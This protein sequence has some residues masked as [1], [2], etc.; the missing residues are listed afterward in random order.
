ML[1]RS[2]GCRLGKDLDGDVAFQLGIARAIDLPHAAAAEERQDRVL[3]D[4]RARGQRHVAS[5][6][7]AAILYR[8]KSICGGSRTS[9]GVEGENR[10]GPE[11][12]QEY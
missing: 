6:I 7:L 8:G 11:L 3:A 1:F 12:S 10:I 9:C 2:G 5:R 4:L